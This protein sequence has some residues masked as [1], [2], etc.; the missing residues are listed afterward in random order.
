M[1]VVIVLFRWLFPIFFL[2]PPVL[3]ILWVCIG[4]SVDAYRR[5]HLDDYP[6]RQLEREGFVHPPEPGE[7]AW[8]A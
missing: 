5:G 8:H 2:G 3:G 6:V 1:V 7:P 4:A